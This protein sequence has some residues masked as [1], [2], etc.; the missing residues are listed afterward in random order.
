MLRTFEAVIV[1][2]RLVTVW[3]QSKVDHFALRLYKTNIYLYLLP[4]A[5]ILRNINVYYKQR[6]RHSK[7]HMF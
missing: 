1:S 2:V 5:A 3:S 4:A 6:N 7:A